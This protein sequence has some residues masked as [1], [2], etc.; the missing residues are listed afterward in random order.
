M[1]NSYRL[2]YYTSLLG[3]WIDACGDEPIIPACNNYADDQ[4]IRYRVMTPSGMAIGKGSG[5]ADALAMVKMLRQYA[6]RD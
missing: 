3:L 2:Q 1:T 6:E 5:H 4:P